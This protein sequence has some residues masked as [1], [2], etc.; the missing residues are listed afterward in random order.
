MRAKRA[1]RSDSAYPRARAAGAVRAGCRWRCP[2]IGVRVCA[3]LE[4]P[5]AFRRHRLADARGTRRNAVRPL[6]GRV[7][8]TKKDFPFWEVFKYQLVDCNDLTDDVKESVSSFLTEENTDNLSENLYDL[9][10]CAGSL[11]RS[12]GSCEYYVLAKLCFFGNLEH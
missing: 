6:R 9:N 12:C 8:P 3:N 1:K 7:S 10:D 2:L 4:A 11:D 5:A